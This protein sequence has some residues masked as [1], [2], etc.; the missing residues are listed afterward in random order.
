MAEKLKSM[1]G[2]DVDLLTADRR[3]G[4]INGV[5]R[6]TLHRP[7][8]DRLT[9]TDRIDDIVTHKLL[10]LP[11]FFVVMYVVFRLVI[12]VSSPFLD[13]TDAVINGPVANWFSFLLDLIIA[14]AWLH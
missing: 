3:Y 2:D 10:G 12:D 13:W 11:V 1:L 4:Y 9:L 6:Q 7:L 14:P 5:V 8:V